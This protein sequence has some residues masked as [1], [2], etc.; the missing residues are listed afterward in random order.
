MKL[1][2]GCGGARRDGYVN[3]DR[4]DS[5]APDLVWDL[6]TT[7]WPFEADSVEEI[8][9]HNVLQQLGQDPAVFLAVVAEMHRV[10]M[11]GGTIDITAPHHRSDMFWDDPANV[12]VISQ[13]VF[14][15]FNK[16]KCAEYRANG[17]AFTP[18]AEEL[19][20]DF[21]VVTIT[22]TLHGDWS[23]RFGA[24]EM[25]QEETTVA[26]AT[27]ANVV[28]TVGLIVRKAAAAVN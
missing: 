3:I 10:L 23:R 18:L 12:R 2:I 22:N 27:N 6:E 7:P 21:E 14:N 17:F 16:A 20:I 25:T 9:A 19:D 5:V 26:V 28:E 15:L 8:V 24:G 4:R 13:G 1:N 11:P